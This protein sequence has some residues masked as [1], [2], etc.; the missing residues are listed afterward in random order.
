MDA[1]KKSRTANLPRIIVRLPP[2]VKAWL[3]AQVDTY[4]SNQASEVVRALRERMERIQQPA[5]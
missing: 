4:Q 1:T 2:E 3:D 5:A